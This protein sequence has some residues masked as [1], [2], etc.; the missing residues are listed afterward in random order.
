MC[1]VGFGLGDPQCT[2][3]IRMGG[4]TKRKEMQWRKSFNVMSRKT[5]R[6][7]CCSQG[8]RCP[9]APRKGGRLERTS[10]RERTWLQRPCDCV[11]CLETR[12]NR[13]LATSQG[14]GDLCRKRFTNQLAAPWELLSLT[15]LDR[16]LQAYTDDT[17][18]AV[19]DRVVRSFEQREGVKLRGLRGGPSRGHEIGGERFRRAR[20]PSSTWSHAKDSGTICGGG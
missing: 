16:D 7:T 5:T 19:R 9:S 3:D 6:S 20:V 18:F 14:Q 4:V 17:R 11:A 12:A 15:L 1:S 2:T 13:S 8:H 10:L